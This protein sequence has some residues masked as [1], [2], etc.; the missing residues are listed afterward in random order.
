M[1]LVV[2]SFVAVEAFPVKAAVIVPA[3][4]SPFTSLTTIFEAMFD[5]VA[6]IIAEFSKLRDDLI[7]AAVFL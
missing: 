7:P 2:A 3:L 6:A 5:E 4:K 1:V